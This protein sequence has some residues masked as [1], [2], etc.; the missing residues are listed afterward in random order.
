MVIIKL[1]SCT[2]YL[3]FKVFNSY[4]YPSGYVPVDTACFHRMN[5]AVAREVASDLICQLL[6]ILFS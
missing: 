6:S 5:H 2:T 3:P 4:M 1:L